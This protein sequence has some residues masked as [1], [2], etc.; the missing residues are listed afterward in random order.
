MHIKWGSRMASSL[1]HFLCT[2]KMDGFMISVFLEMRLISAAD[3]NEYFEG[4]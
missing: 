1:K 3:S 4:T 2:A